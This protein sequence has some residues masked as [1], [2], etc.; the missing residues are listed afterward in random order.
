MKPLLLIVLGLAF[1]SCK[2]HDQEVTGKGADDSKDS[3]SAHSGAYEDVTFF[4]DHSSTR[5]NSSAQ[6]FAAF[7]NA[8]ITLL[9]SQGVTNIAE[10]LRRNA[11]QG[12]RI[13]HMFGILNN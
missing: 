2:E 6:I 12:K 7:R 1:I 9:R 13:L 4:E 8:A 5:T 11:Y 10:A 3:V